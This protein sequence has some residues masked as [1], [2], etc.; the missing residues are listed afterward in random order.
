MHALVTWGLGV[1][2]CNYAA[3]NLNRVNQLAPKKE[4]LILYNSLVAP[5]LNYADTI[6]GG[7]GSKNTNKL[8]RTQNAAVKSMLG[9]K[10]QDSATEA[11]KTA[12]LHPLE[13]KR[14]IHEAVYAHK[15][16]K[17]NLPTAIC[18]QYQQ[19][20]SQ[21]NNRSTARQ[22]LTIP[23]HRTELYKK[24]PLYRTIKTWNSIPDDIKH[25]ETTTS[26][27]KK[28]QSHLL[29]TFKT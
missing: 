22:V 9:R 12:N 5:H 20:Q 15:A 19:Q 24:S 16:L 29:N 4:R 28:F 27:R 7:C 2:Q 6:W 14:R 8:Q 1:T 26:F 3:I 23:I 17:G 10:K 13:E 21:M 11:L 25:T 18:R